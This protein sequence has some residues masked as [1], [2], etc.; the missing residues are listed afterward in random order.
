MPKAG[1]HGVGRSPPPS[2]RRRRLVSCGALPDLWDLQTWKRRSSGGLL[3][4]RTNKVILGLDE[5]VAVYHRE[6]EDRSPAGNLRQ[7]AILFAIWSRAGIWMSSHDRSK[8]ARFGAVAELQS[9]AWK[10]LE[11]LRVRQLPTRRLPPGEKFRAA[12]GLL[13]GGAAPGWQ[14]T[15]PMHKDAYFLE[16]WGDD[17]VAAHASEN[18]FRYWLDLFQ[19]KTAEE[20]G[21]LVLKENAP[22]FWDWWTSQ[23]LY[24]KEGVLYLTAEE[25]EAYRVDVSPRGL[26]WACGAGP[27]H[28]MGL[29]WIGEEDD[30]FI[31]VVSRDAVLYANQ[32]IGGTFHHSSFLGGMP[33]LGAGQL[34]VEEGRLTM[35]SNSSGHYRPDPARH[36]NALL[37]FRRKGVDLSTVR[38]VLYGEA[39]KRE[40]T[41]QEH[42]AELAAQY[43][44]RHRLSPA[45]KLELFAALSPEAKRKFLAERGL[46]EDQYVRP[47]TEA[48]AATLYGSAAG[49]GAPS[50][51]LDPEEAAARL[52]DRPAGSTDDVD[53]APARP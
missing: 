51:A 43:A 40:A 12:A 15:K 38:S 13:T 22:S 36:F 34:I 23:K 25:R 14:P 39:G 45:K 5:L 1:R 41:G 35:V 18:A 4:R 44:V 53:Y 46:T 2:L 7:T 24:K 26:S 28:S 31:F 48:A 3:A 21:E 47:L 16:A 17:H 37:F 32:G 42:Y 19:D 50:A 27:L 33:V 20:R 29:Q 6:A 52:F 8:C 11:A 10:L 9:Q 49:T 30:V